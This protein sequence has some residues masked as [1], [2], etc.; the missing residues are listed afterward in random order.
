MGL[1]ASQARLLSITARLSDNELHSQQIANAK[2]RLADQAQEASREYVNSLDAQKLV[3]TMYDAKG[4][5]TKV[6]LTPAVMYE[7]AEMKNQYGISNNAGQL[8]V[9]STDA[10]HYQDSKNL[11]EFL[12]SYGIKYSIN[13]NYISTLQFAYGDNNDKH[14]YTHFYDSASGKITDGLDEINN[15]DIKSWIN[16]WNENMT[17]QEYLDWYNELSVLSVHKEN[18][19]G[20][21]KEL[22]DELLAVPGSPAIKGAWDSFGNTVCIS[23]ATRS[24]SFDLWK[25]NENTTLKNDMVYH[26]EHV[27]CHMLK[28][29]EENGEYTTSDGNTISLIG[30]KYGDWKN[31]N[32][33]YDDDSEKKASKDMIDSLEGYDGIKQQIIDL[34]YA[35]VYHLVQN[36]GYGYKQSSSTGS[37]YT[38]DY[39]CSIT[40]IKAAWNE[41]AQTISTAADDNIAYSEIWKAKTQ[42]LYKNFDDLTRKNIPEYKIF[43]E[44]N[45]K[46]AWYT[47]LWYR[48]NGASN[49]KSDDGVNGRYWK[50]L[51]DN[52]YNSSSWLQFALEQG[53][54][55]LEQVQFEK[56]AE[57]GTGITNAKW[58]PKI[59]TTCTDIQFVDDETAVARAEAIYT[60]KLNEIEVKDKKYD[61][62]IKK[63]DTEHNALQTEYESIKSV[64]DKNVER[65]FKAFS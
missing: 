51:E 65:S 3:Y 28:A 34:Y 1:S 2:V 8:L 62:D 18:A 26:M 44:T 25:I 10:K 46:T 32:A 50:Q 40:D 15:G 64:V 6:N 36:R 13:E 22:I 59:F 19:S 47:N 45:P 60:R 52:L 23:D 43:D 56:P 41:L 37:S 12:E 5:S 42:Y 61:N 30:C 39:E 9:S 58:A 17:V 49:T 38:D 16:Q 21:Y 24:T 33:F 31:G 29:A 20:Q 54:V 27:L 53:L 7:Y 14:Y 57:S 63:L 4:N 48:M 11:T 35:V 55:T